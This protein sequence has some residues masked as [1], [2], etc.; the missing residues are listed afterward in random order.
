MPSQADTVYGRRAWGSPQNPV[1]SRPLAKPF[2]SY[3]QAATADALQAA[4]DEPSE[5]IRE[6]RPPLAID[7]FPPRF[8]YEHEELRIQDVARLDDRYERRDFSG[9]KSGYESSITPSLPLG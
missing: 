3:E 7:P 4:M 8:G 2:D 1:P 6:R 5:L 9:K